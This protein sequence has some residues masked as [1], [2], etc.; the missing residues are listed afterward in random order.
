MDKKILAQRAR[1]IESHIEKSQPIGEE[2]DK[3]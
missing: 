3:T 1:L 2:I